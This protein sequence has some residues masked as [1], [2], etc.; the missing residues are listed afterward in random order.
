MK[1]VNSEYQEWL[2]SIL[3][4]H[5]VGRD[6]RSIKG[7]MTTARERGHIAWVLV[8]MSDGS[9]HHQQN[10]LQL[11]QEAVNYLGNNDDK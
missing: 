5:G 4:E 10:Q 2:I 7:F 8:D 3:I 9:D 11:T 1:P 6:I